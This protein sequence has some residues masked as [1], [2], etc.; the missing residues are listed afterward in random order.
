MARYCRAGVDT[1]TG[2]NTHLLHLSV[3][4][5]GRKHEHLIPLLSAL[6]LLLQVQ[7]FLSMLRLQ[8]FNVLLLLLNHPASLV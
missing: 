5:V 6:E 1:Q 4:L 7:D 2:T 3:P 8:L